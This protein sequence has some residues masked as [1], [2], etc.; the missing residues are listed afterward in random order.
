MKKLEN[1]EK[2]IAWC[3]KQTQAPMLMH[4]VSSLLIFWIV[5]FVMLLIDHQGH[6]N[7][8]SSDEIV[9]QLVEWTSI[10]LVFGLSNR[11]YLKYQLK[12]L[13]KKKELILSKND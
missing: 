13:R 2:H 1:I 3:E 10:G 8:M 12:R 4:I 6:I 5:G 7:Q 9:D 11:W